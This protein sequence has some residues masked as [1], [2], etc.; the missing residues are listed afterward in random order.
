MLGGGPP[1]HLMWSS[2]YS[3]DRPKVT[4]RVDVRRILAFFRPYTVQE[5]LVLVCILVV[6]LLGLLPPLFTKWLIDGAIPAHDMH[7]VLT[8]RRRDGRQRRRSP[9]CSA[10]TR[11]TSTRW[12]AR[13]SCATSARAWSR[14]CTACR[15]RS[16]PERRPARS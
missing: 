15:S 13:G 5:S 1:V 12:S 10:S 9:A 4:K 14:T 11:A 7:G 16:S 8:R 3:P 6:A 2:M